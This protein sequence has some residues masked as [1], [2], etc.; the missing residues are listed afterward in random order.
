MICVDFRN[1]PPFNSFLSGGEWN[2]FEKRLL[3][4]TA[5][6]FS[7]EIAGSALQKSMDLYFEEM[8]KAGID[9]VVVPVR[10]SAGGKNED[11]LLL[12]ERYPDKIIGIISVPPFSPGIEEAVEKYITAGPCAGITFEP[13]LDEEPWLVDDLRMQG[14]YALCEAKSV[15]VLF[16][17][18]GLDGVAEGQMRAVEN[19]AKKFPAL[20]IILC[21]GCWPETVKS[22]Q[23]AA[24]YE[25]I[26]LCVDVY[27]MNVPGF[28]HY[29]AAANNMIPDKIL[30]GS[31]YP[32]ASMESAAA[33]YRSG[34]LKEE[35]LEKVMGQNALK[36]LGLQK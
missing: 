17:L 4:K 31:A 25:N 3:E 33:F 27:L 30:F 22:C 10:C 24:Y 9:K 26:Y 23:L 20:K 18:G 19:I 21:H 36:V 16:T 29:A 13:S 12:T 1:R 15:P 7:S 14:V 11:L 32:L 35:V 6:Y 28:E 8:E 5:R 34:I 2:L